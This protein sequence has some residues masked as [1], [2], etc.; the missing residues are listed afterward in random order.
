M[1]INLETLKIRLYKKLG[2]RIS[3]SSAY[4]LLKNSLFTLKLVDIITNTHNTKITNK[5]LAITL[6]RRQFELDV[7]VE[8]YFNGQSWV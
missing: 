3:T 1:F 6:I 5:K 2:I 8:I 4:R 7:N